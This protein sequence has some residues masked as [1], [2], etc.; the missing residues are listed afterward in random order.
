MISGLTYV[1]LISVFA[2]DDTL[3]FIT[4]ESAIECVLTFCV[5]LELALFAVWLIYV[6][7]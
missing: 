6:D 1:Y 2:G 3:Y 4:Q 5:R 7:Y